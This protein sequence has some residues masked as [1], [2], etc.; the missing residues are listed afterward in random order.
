MSV[1]NSNSTATLPY[2]HLWF[3]LRSL[4]IVCTWRLSVRKK[5]WRK[6]DGPP[7]V[8][9]SIYRLTSR[10]TLLVVRPRRVSSMSSPGAR[11]S[12]NLKFLRRWWR[13]LLLCRWRPL[14]Q[15]R[16]IGVSFLGA[17]STGRSSPYE[18]ATKM[19][20]LLEIVHAMDQVLY[21]LAMMLSEQLE[22]LS[23]VNRDEDVRWFF[24]NFEKII[25]RGTSV[26]VSRFGD[27]ATVYSPSFLNKMYKAYS[28]ASF[29]ASCMI[30]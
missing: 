29:V 2:L 30:K 12:G 11:R 3:S 15:S 27:L 28:A 24:Q 9:T 1:E 4:S 17:V 22:Q 16:E 8:K 14:M 10:W 19:W 18:G 6:S 13:S 5:K 21:P 26:P 23:S 7:V 25:P 20:S